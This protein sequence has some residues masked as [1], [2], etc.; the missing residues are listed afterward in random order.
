MALT[1]TAT[2]VLQNHVIG[3]LRMIDPVIIEIS[4][5]KDNLSFSVVDFESIVSLLCRV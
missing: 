3:I 2:K 5:E 4:P 1:A